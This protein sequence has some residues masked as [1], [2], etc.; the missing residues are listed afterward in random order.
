MTSARIVP[1]TPKD[2]TTSLEVLKEEI[3]CK[4]LL[5]PCYSFVLEGNFFISNWNDLVELILCSI[6]TSQQMNF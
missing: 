3:V 4:F 1:A 6:C 2:V 5:N